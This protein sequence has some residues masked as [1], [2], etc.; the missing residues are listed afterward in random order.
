MWGCLIG[1]SWEVQRLSQD[2]G[3]SFGSG[4]LVDVLSGE[5]SKAFGSG[6]GVMSAR[7]CRRIARVCTPVEGFAVCMADFCDLVSGVV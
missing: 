4:S 7:A 5:V 3:G 1:Q 2:G 6:V